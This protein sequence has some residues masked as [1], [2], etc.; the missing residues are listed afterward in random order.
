MGGGRFGIWNISV[1]R[2]D[3]NGSETHDEDGDGGYE[4]GDDDW[5]YV[6]DNN[7]NSRYH[8]YNDNDQGGRI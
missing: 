5:D 1:E 2:E 8:E 6:L 4:D 3:E 7:G